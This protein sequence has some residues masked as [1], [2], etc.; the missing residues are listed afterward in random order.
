M[1]PKL[2]FVQSIFSS[3]DKTPSTLEMQN[4]K[5]GFSKV[6]QRILT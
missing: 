6:K 5:T 1:N 4:I 3:N 2:K